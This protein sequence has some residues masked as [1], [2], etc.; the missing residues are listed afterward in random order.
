MSPEI[1]EHKPYNQG[2]DVYSFGIVLYEMLFLT[3]PVP[4]MKS[5]LVDTICLHGQIYYPNSI[6]NVILRCL[7]PAIVD[8]PPMKEIHLALRLSISEL[9][10]LSE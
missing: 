3:C 7:S 6:I 1:S 5:G 9:T 2:A 4:R 10:L 8:R